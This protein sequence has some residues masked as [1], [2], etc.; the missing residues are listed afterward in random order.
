M[1]LPFFLAFPRQTPLAS[2]FKPVTSE[3]PLDSIRDFAWPSVK[4]FRPATGEPGLLRSDLLMAELLVPNWL[5]D[6]A[7][8]LLPARLT[9]ARLVRVLG[10]FARSFLSVVRFPLVVER[11]AHSKV[12][13]D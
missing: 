6:F 3:Y 10:L 13:R 2:F 4:L 7:S 12:P 9:T 8:A 1:A 11:F 5:E